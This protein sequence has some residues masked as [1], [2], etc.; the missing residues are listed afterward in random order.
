MNLK[1]IRKKVNTILSDYNHARKVVI[2]EKTRLRDAKILLDEE[3]Q[4]QHFFQLVAQGVQQLAIG[5]IA[6]VISK[7]LQS[8][9]FDE[10]IEFRVNFNRARGK[11][12]AELA[13]V[14]EGHE[15]EPKD[16]AGGVIAVSSLAS[17]LTSLSLK[18]PA[19]R[20]LLIL[21][22]PLIHLSREYIPAAKEL[23]ISLAEDFSLQ[24][25]MVTH[26]RGLEIGKVVEM[27]D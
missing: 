12:E 17:R 27:G 21:D 5:Q 19:G 20:K 3:Q 11:T 25:I 24:I 23:L 4:A 8:V 1:T 9:F 10:E 26:I 15:I 13:I 6:S 16:D 18:R 14:R 7:C 22:E 2:E